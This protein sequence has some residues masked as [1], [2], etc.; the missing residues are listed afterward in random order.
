MSLTWTTEQ[1]I[2]LAPDASSAKA[3]K[4]IATAR[5]WVSLGY[6]EQAA[7]GECPGSGKS[8][9]RTQIDLSE[10]AFNC[11]CPSH[12]FPCK[13]A[14]GLFLLL[15]SQPK[16]FNENAAPDWVTQ[17]L[18]SRARR[19]SKSEQTQKPR[20][21]AAQAKRASERETKVAAGLKELELWICDL[22]HQGLASVQSRPDSLFE[23]MAA[24]LVDAQAPGAA[25]LLRDM[26]GISSSGSGW[27]NRLLERVS[28]LFLLIEGFKRIDTLPVDTQSDIRATLGW[29]QNQDELLAEPG[30]R[31]CWQ[32]LGQRI[33]EEDRLRVQ[34]A[35]LCGRESRKIA[36]VL[37][38]AH[39]NQPL[40]L[41]LTPGV[42]VDAELV[43]YKSAHTLRALI[44]QR[45]SSTSAMTAAPVATNVTA[46]TESY[47]A[48]L[49]RNPWLERFPVLLRAAIPMRRGE[50]WNVRDEDGR[51][52]QIAPRFKRAWELLSLSGGRPLTLFGEWDGDYLL[53]LSAFAEDRFV[54]L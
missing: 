38:F 7:W 3:G 42:E 25:R 51:F 28:R 50:I 35:W 52:M 16:A 8:P 54:L 43:F 14:L 26:A 36:L 49:S 40:V 24:R 46:A 11:T 10:P 34:S 9:Y 22:A 21:P 19:A 20:N 30:L 12:K 45:Y 23:A 17:W 48:A 6:D 39:G 29:T 27:Q 31:D 4:A 15:D 13:H 2:A 41:S 53:P 47:A 44:K 33:E 37:N 5:K 32:V 1:I 18:A